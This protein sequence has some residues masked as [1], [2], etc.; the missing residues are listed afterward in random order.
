MDCQAD[1]HSAQAVCSVGLYCTVQDDA[2][3]AMVAQ[4]PTVTNCGIRLTLLD[5][6]EPASECCDL[7][8]SEIQAEVRPASHTAPHGITVTA[9]VRPHHRRFP[10]AVTVVRCNNSQPT[11]VQKK[12]WKRVI[13]RPTCC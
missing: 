4:V 7:R 5:N 3:Q 9:D 10:P 11:K 13:R 1:S 2:Q 8:S 6:F 12:V